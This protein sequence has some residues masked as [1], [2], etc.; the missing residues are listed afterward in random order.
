MYYI[1][2]LIFIFQRCYFLSQ[3]LEQERHELRLLLEQI[4]RECDTKIFESNEDKSELRRQANDLRR[5][6][7]LQD[8]QHTQTIRELTELN[9]KL[10]QDLEIVR[11]L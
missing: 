2:L 3:V 6:Q 5:E 10:S 1:N 9:H 7:R 11:I 4:Q 8:E